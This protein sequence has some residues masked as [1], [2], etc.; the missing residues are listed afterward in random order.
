M[1]YI[2]AS[3]ASSGLDSGSTTDHKNRNSLAPSR[4]AASYSSSGIECAKNVRAMMTC[5][6]PIA[7]GISNAHRVFNM[8]TSWTTM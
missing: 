5:H 4:V 3:T 8:P 1:A 2:S 6:T 7:L